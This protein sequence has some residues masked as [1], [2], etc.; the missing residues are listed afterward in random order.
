MENAKTDLPTL[1]TTY[2][3][4]RALLARILRDHA[5]IPDKAWTTK[6]RLNG[7]TRDEFIERLLGR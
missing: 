3:S 5:R 1:L 6:R 4:A 7:E 2:D